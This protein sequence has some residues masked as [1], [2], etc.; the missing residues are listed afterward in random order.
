[1]PP[2]KKNATTKRVEWRDNA[3]YRNVFFTLNNYTD[4]SLNLLKDWSQ[5]SY[6]IVGK[7]VA[8]TGTPHLQGYAEFKQQVKGSVIRKKLMGADLSARYTTSPALHTANYCRKGRQ[9]KAE[10]EE[11]GE[12][13][14]SY[15]LD[16]DVLEWGTIS[17]PQGFRS[18]IAKA[19]DMLLEGK[20]MKEVSLANPEVFI[21]HATNLVKF[22]VLHMPERCSVPNIIVHYGST[23]TGKNYWAKKYFADRGVKPYIWD[24]THGA[25]FWLDYEGEEDIIVNEFRG[26][27]E[28][29]SLLTLT[30]ENPLKVQIKGG[31]MQ[32]RGINFIFTSPTHPRKWYQCEGEDRIDQFMRRVGECRVFDVPFDIK[33]H[34][35]IESRFD[36]S[37]PYTNNL[38]TKDLTK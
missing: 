26:D 5:V 4:N 29:S 24:P 10:W 30:D 31:S 19:T 9:P 36:P 21:K 11:F 3:K 12:S 8:Q 1:M 20:N 34:T 2:K 22:Q 18:D 37:V 27:I 23:G 13:G 35:P 28:F 14:P 25:K 32:F 38:K 33:K 7:E 15:G 6:A 17:L 16:A